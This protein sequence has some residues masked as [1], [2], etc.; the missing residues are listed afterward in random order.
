VSDHNIS[1]NQTNN[2]SSN[3]SA[4]NRS[5]LAQSNAFSNQVCTYLLPA[6]EYNSQGKR[7][8]TTGRTKGGA[9][10]LLGLYPNPGTGQVFY[11]LGDKGDVQQ[12]RV[13][14]AQGREVHRQGAGPDSG[15]L[16]LGSLP[17]GLYLI[18]ATLAGG[19]TYTQKWILQR[20]K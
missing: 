3:L 18:R 12:I 5:R 16:Q 13:F 14:D 8:P 1:Q 17:D 19:Q 4:A 10:A 7:A 20:E 11:N 2:F 6:N 9:D 15:S